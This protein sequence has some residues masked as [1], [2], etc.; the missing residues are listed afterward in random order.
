MGTGELRPYGRPSC[1]RAGYLKR[2]RLI[3]DGVKNMKEKGKPQNILKKEFYISLF[4]SLVWLGYGIVSVSIMIFYNKTGVY[5]CG[6]TM[7]RDCGI[8]EFILNSDS[9][10]IFYSSFVILFAGVFL[11][12]SIIFLILGCI[13]KNF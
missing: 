12:S 3:L 5:T 1:F 10:F 13:K 9:S 11:L 6:I 4:S 8:I 7:P 2:L